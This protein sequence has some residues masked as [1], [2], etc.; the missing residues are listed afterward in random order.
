MLS[1]FGTIVQRC[2]G[3]GAFFLEWI[4]SLMCIVCSIRVWFCEAPIARNDEC[5]AEACDVVFDDEF[6]VEDTASCAAFVYHLLN[7]EFGHFGLR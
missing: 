2:E 4:G 3:E 1:L 7:A 5:E 6:V